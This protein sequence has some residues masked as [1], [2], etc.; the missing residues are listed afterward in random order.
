MRH[1]RM[2]SLV[3]KML[4]LHKKLQK[5]KTPHDKELI[6]RRIKSTDKEI[7]ALVYELYGLTDEEI[8]I[9]EGGE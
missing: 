7:D 4:E 8:R 9:V 6:E 3:E 1:D 5:A 2:V